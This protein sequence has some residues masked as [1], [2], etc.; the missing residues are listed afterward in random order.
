VVEVAV[1]M[2]R[3]EAC[4]VEWI[5]FWGVGLEEGEGRVSYVPVEQR[6]VLVWAFANVYV[7]DRTDKRARAW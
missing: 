7:C 2:V 3:C 5:L 1:L 4:I 6:T